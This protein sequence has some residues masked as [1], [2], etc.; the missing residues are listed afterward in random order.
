MF[1]ICYLVFGA[2]KHSLFPFFPKRSEE[3]ACVQLK[4]NICHS[5][6]FPDKKLK[7]NIWIE[8]AAFFLL[9]SLKIFHLFSQPGTKYSSS[10]QT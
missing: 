2:Y 9:F 6:I 5:G 8:I 10:P 3:D 1:E 4:G 7:D